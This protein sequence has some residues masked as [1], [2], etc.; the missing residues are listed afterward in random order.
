[1]KTVLCF[2]L[3]LFFFTTNV[4]SHE[5]W[6]DKHQ[7]SYF[8]RYGH[9]NFSHN[10]EQQK[11]LIAYKPDNVLEF[12]CFDKTGHKAPARINRGFPCELCG[13][14][15]AV[16]SVFSTG[17]WTKTPYGTRNIPRDEAR[18]PVYSWYSVESVKLINEWNESMEKPLT[19]SLE[20]VPLNNLSELEKNDKVRLLVT[21][22]KHPLKGVI[23]TYDGNPRGTTG[24]DGR[25]NIRIKHGGFQ[26]ISAT[27]K[28][29]T[30]SPKADETIRTANLNF[31]VK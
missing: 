27:F 4:F 30:A 6:I 23:V 1:M 19:D 5:L 8:I 25:I 9:L 17:Y 18:M 20:I 2:V 14:C 12:L 7:G 26:V 16:F 29:K 13:N 11:K 24:K 28:E 31:E 3:F 10:G 15:A 21:Y 22:Q